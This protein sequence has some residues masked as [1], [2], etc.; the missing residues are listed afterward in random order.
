MVLKPQSGGDY[1]FGRLIKSHNL[2]DNR[3]F[4]IVYCLQFT[5]FQLTDMFIEMSKMT[6]TFTLQSF[7]GFYRELI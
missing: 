5:L 1:Y 7:L 4:I 6:L 3:I 2:R